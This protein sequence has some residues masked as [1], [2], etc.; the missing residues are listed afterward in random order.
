[1]IEEKNGVIINF[2]SGWGRSTSP[3]VVPYCTTKWA[4]EGLS[5]SLGLHQ[6]GM[7]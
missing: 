3:E 6:S 7:I 4:I 5:Q 2:S 1:M